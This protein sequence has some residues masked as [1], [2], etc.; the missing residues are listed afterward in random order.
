MFKSSKPVIINVEL[1]SNYANMPIQMQQFSEVVK[2]I[3]LD[4]Q[5]FFHIVAQNID[6]G[7]MLG[8]PH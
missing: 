8:L 4:E 2:A 5:I 7:Y 3:I 6:C 1:S